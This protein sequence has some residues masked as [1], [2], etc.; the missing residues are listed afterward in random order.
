MADRQFLPRT[1]DGAAP[2][3]AHEIEQTDHR[4]RP[5]DFIVDEDTARRLGLPK[6]QTI[7]DRER[8]LDLHIPADNEA[9]DEAQR[10][11][12]G[13]DAHRR[14]DELEDRFTAME[15]RLNQIATGNAA[16][17]PNASTSPANASPAAGSNAASS[18]APATSTDPNDRLAGTGG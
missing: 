17:V 13:D 12:D 16:L 1:L 3:T 8:F 4:G 10:A 18:A 2:F 7:V 5:G 6:G 15:R 14:I 11:G 9:D